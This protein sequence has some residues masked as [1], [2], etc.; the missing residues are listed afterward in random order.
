VRS[1]LAAVLVLCASAALALAAD[2]DPSEKKWVGTCV[3]NLAA[4]SA[5]VRG[6]AE[7]A[8]SGLGQAALPAVVAASVKLKTDDEWLG[9]SRGIAGMGAGMRKAVDDLRMSWPKGTEKR[10]AGMLDFLEKAEAEAKASGVVALPSSPGDVKA[11]VNEIL[12]GYRDK[13]VMSTEDPA[14]ADLIA[15]GH[16]AVGA[17]LEFLDGRD[18]TNEVTFGS[19]SGKFAAQHALASLADASDAPSLI[20][21]LRKGRTTVAPALKN[22]DAPGVLDAFIAAIDSTFVDSELL[23]GLQRRGKEPRV[24]KAL[25]AWLRKPAALEHEW[26][27]GNVAEF[28]AENEAPDAVATLTP[29]LKS[30]TD[31]QPRQYVALAL[32]NL[33]E[34]S[35]IAVL[36]EVLTMNDSHAGMGFDYPR[37]CAGNALNRISGTTIYAGKEVG[38]GGP[39]SGPPRYDADW[40]AVAKE[41]RE[42]WTKN[43]DKLHFDSE[44]RTWSVQ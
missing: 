42:W 1:S 2:L 3:D 30:L 43:K 41:F 20:A 14:I 34:K 18:A 28:L 31:L 27:V 17:L 21:L 29:L 22:I 11:R 40:G 38:G 19:H 16:P 36:I 37:H 44:T 25:C 33:G 13:H 39:G 5:L 24:Q 4:K 10:F 26:V 15:L 12:D 23:E 9:L 6:S 7:R 35:G 32:A 8:I